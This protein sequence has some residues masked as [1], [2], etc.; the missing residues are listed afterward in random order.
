M[1]D[2]ERYAG[3]RSW[4]GGGK[5]G[6]PSDSMCGRDMRRSAAREGAGLPQ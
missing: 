5:C 2:V 6:A 4:E 3:R 1:L